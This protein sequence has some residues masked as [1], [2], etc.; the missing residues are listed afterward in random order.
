L[1]DGLD[2]GD[3]TRGRHHSFA[4]ERLK[5]DLGAAGV[6]L[7]E[8][9]RTHRAVVAIKMQESERRK[10]QPKQHLKRG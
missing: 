2:G 4:Q 9:K 6:E 3:V 8:E 1:E 5:H 7:V 10:E